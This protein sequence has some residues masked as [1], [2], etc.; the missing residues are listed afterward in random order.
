[1]SADPEAPE[2]HIFDAI[3]YAYEWVTKEEGRNAGLERSGKGREWYHY[4]EGDASPNNVIALQ[5]GVLE[6]QAAARQT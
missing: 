1:M 6:G 2:R 3:G 4:F 5:L